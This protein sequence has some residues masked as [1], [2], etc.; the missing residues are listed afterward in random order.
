MSGLNG[1]APVL[2]IRNL[3]AGYNHVPA[4]EDITLQATQGQILGIIGPNGSGKS[5]LFKVV[6]GLLRPWRGEVL[7]FGKPSPPNDPSSATCPKWNWWTGTFLSPSEMWPLWD[8]TD[9]WG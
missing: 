9:D 5:T 7:V 1:G 8:V 3:S 6:L 4:I 2:D